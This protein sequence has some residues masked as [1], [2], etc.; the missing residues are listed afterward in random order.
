METYLSNLLKRN[1][2]KFQ[3]GNHFE[4][5][6][7]GEGNYYEV[8]CDYFQNKEIGNFIDEQIG[9][10]STERVLL[11]VGNK[12]YLSEDNIDELRAVINLNPVNRIKHVNGYLAS[13]NKLLPDAGIFIGR[14]E[15]YTERKQR[16]KKKFGGAWK[17]FYSFDFVVNRV[18][19]R[20]RIFEKLY[21]KFTNDCYHVMSKAEILGRLVYSGFDIIDFKVMDG[22]LYYVVMKTQE[23]R[24]TP[25]TFHPLIKLLRIGKGGKVLPV[26]KLRTMHPYSEYLQGFVTK[27]NGY[28]KAG[29]PANDFRLASWGKFMRK[30]W[31]DEFPQ[32]INLVTGKMKLVGVRPLSRV[33]FNELPDDVKEM[34]IRHKPGCFPPYVALCMPDEHQNIEAEIIYMQEKEENPYTTDMKYLFMSV[35]NILTNKIRSA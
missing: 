18:I 17:L 28:N 26:Y 15:T 31:L 16:F 24:E 7:S 8:I 1:K 10:L 11:S 32:C 5:R 4:S 3:I 20:M 21:A 34:R 29:K 30:Y 35:Y 33:R 27:L 19:P 6:V 14:M 12:T 13:V 22:M 23:P 9:L 2:L 25:A